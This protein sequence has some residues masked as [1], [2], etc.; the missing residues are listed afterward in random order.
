MYLLP[1][2]FL[3][4]RARFKFPP[5]ALLAIF[6][7]WKVQNIPFLKQS[8]TAF[9]RKISKSPQNRGVLR[10]RVHFAFYSSF[11]RRFAESWA[12][13]WALFAA[14]S[15]TMGQ[16]AQLDLLQM[17]FRFWKWFEEKENKFYTF[18]FFK[19]GCAAFSS[20]MQ[21]NSRQYNL[22][23]W[24]RMLNYNRP[25]SYIFWKCIWNFLNDMKNKYNFF[26]FNFPKRLCTAWDLL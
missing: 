26:N 20:T 5:T 2:P 23:Q 9:N 24:D 12:E 15:S 22:M 3:K 18:I 21:C 19:R 7:R 16:N 14:F 10:K 13:R 25:K 11:W 4:I 17:Y 8:G 1:P 6:F